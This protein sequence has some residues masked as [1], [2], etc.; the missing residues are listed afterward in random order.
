MP[1]DKDAFKNALGQF[2]AGV[3]VITVQAGDKRHG[4]TAT[5]LSSVCAEPP[6]ISVVIDHRGYAQE[7]FQQS[8]AVFAVNILKADQEDYANR[9]AFSKEDRFATG[10]WTTAATG[11]PIL[12][13]ALVWMDCTIFS[14]VTAGNNTIYIG[15]IQA[16]SVLE[17][18]EKPLL[19]WNRDYRSL[20][21]K[22]E[23]EEVLS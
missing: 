16:S 2:A 20:T 7:L 23:K 9:F 21:Q 4:L 17:T 8:D 10:N 15:E 18:D 11:A 12:E 5:S 22:I 3:T 13:D 1:I 19:Y 14:R 6:L